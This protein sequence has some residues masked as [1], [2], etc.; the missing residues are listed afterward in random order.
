MES[1]S[2]LWRG[3]TDILG[4]QH[5][6]DVAPLAF[7]GHDRDVACGM[8]MLLTWLQQPISTLVGQHRMNMN[9]RYHFML[10]ESVTAFTSTRF[11]QSL[12][13]ACR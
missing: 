9:S 11:V 3:R 13:E 6:A 1:G 8:M 4:K 12:I 2:I 10:H 7:N 5:R